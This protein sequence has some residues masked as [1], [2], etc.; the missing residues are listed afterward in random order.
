MFTKTI[1]L[2]TIAVAASATM[3]PKAAPKAP[4]KKVAPTI[5]ATPSQHPADFSNESFLGS[6]AT[7][8]QAE[9][10]RAVFVKR[11]LNLVKARHLAAYEYFKAVDAEK[12]AKTAKIAAI[13]TWNKAC[14]AHEDAIKAHQ[15]A[16]VAMTK[17]AGA[18]KVATAHHTLTKSKLADAIKRRALYKRR[19]LAGIK[20]EHKA[21]M[22][23]IKSKMNLKHWISVVATRTSRY[24]S[25]IKTNVH[26]V[27]VEA[28]ARKAE[29][30]AIAAH[31]KAKAV[32]KAA[33]A[34]ERLFARNRATAYSNQ[35]AAV[36]AHKSAVTVAKKSRAEAVAA[37]HR[38]KAHAK[39]KAQFAL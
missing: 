31:H 19:V 10:R 12:A 24:N 27:K 4:V 2:L 18:R 35:K 5:V 23:V 16:V 29:A 21:R 36:A 38:V 6:E 9:D 28:A 11:H 3:P 34:S 1:I 8:K 14:T 7:F 13:A 30:A 15:R 32:A 37:D 26:W 17:A 33:K 22:S 20:A 39:A 25:A